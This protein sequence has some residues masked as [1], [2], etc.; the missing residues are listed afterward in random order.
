MSIEVPV[1]EGKVATKKQLAAVFNQ[2]F[3]HLENASSLCCRV[4][5][6]LSEIAANGVRM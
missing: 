6:A 4:E 1:V 5:S 2:L 3:P